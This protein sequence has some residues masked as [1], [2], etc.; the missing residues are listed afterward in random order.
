MLRAGL[1]AACCVL[2]IA[3]AAWA[4]ETHPPQFVAQMDRHLVTATD[5]VGATT[6]AAWTFGSGSETDV[7]V[8]ARDA[9]G[10]WSQP[11]LFGGGDG[12]D[13]R[14]PALAVDDRGTLYLAFTERTS[15]RVLVAALASGTSEWVGP[16]PI[17]QSGSAAIGLRV[18]GSRLVVGFVS[19]TGSVSMRDLPL[20]DSELQVNETN[21]GPDPVSMGWPELEVPTPTVKKNHGSRMGAASSPEGR[22]LTEANVID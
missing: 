22:K 18:L 7:A 9:A 20:F 14:R 13:Q 6:W 1:R 3:P 5:S 4:G 21:D 11:V 10:M 15:G 17:A 2:A 8:A 19:A 16:T 12:E